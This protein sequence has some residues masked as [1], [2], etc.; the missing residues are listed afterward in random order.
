M[1]IA[2]TIAFSIAVL[3]LGMPSSRDFDQVAGRYLI[4]RSKWFW[5]SAVL[6]G[7]LAV[8]MLLFMKEMEITIKIGDAD[9]GFVEYSWLYGVFAGLFYQGIIYSIVSMLSL[10][11]VGIKEGDTTIKS[12]M[13][14]YSSILGW[15]IKNDIDRISDVAITP[16]KRSLLK[17]EDLKIEDIVGAFFVTGNSEDVGWMVDQIREKKEQLTENGFDI[18]EEKLKAPL[19]EDILKQFLIAKGHRQFR[20]AIA[21]V[22]ANLRDVKEPSTPIEEF[23]DKQN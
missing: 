6:H 14:F 18:S 16:P 13:D 9:K 23:A 12:S 22:E 8:G 4:W 1:L 21:K 3:L 15:L 19:L 7:L 10:N 11:G 20:R 2:S 5:I 17:L